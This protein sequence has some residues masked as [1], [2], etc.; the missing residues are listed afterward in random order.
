MHARSRSCFAFK[1]NN[2]IPGPKDYSRKTCRSCRRVGH[3]QRQCPGLL[4][5]EGATNPG[6]ATS[7]S[8]PPEPMEVDPEPSIELEWSLGLLGTT[9]RPGKETHQRGRG[10]RGAASA[11]RS[12]PPQTQEQWMVARRAWIGRQVAR[13]FG[14]LFRGCT[15]HDEVQRRYRALSRRIHPNNTE[16][17]DHQCFLNLQRVHEAALEEYPP[18][19]DP[20]MGRAWETNRPED[21]IMYND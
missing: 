1:G 16:T 5:G 10:R 6:R 7:R 19:Q 14:I 15:S 9:R 3:I 11:S 12:T 18:P 4:A 2:T 17:G 21:D 8:P 20:W 13:P